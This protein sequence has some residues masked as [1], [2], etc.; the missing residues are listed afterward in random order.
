M[1]YMK[2]L[3]MFMPVMLAACS[4][5][6]W[7]ALADV[8]VPKKV[9]SGEFVRFVEDTSGAR[10]QTS[11]TAYRNADGV[12]VTLIGA[13]H[14]ADS[15]YYD[16]LND[17]FKS[18]DAVLYE[19][20]GGPIEKREE[21]MKA[22]EESHVSPQ[23]DKKNGADQATEPPIIQNA[24]ASPNP[25][26]Q[27]SSHGGTPAAGGDALSWL[28]ML[29][30]MLQN[31]LALE[32]QLDGIDYHQ[33]NFV[34][35]DMSLEEFSSMQQE[36]QEGFLALW[37]KAVQVQI[38][39]PQVTA[40]QPGLLQIL[41]IL[42]RQDSATE[43]KRLIGRTFD[44]VEGLMAGMEAGDGTVIITE[45]NKV[46]LKVMDEQIKAGKRNLAIFYGSAHLPDMEKRLQDM[47]FKKQQTTWMTAW[48]LPPPA[49]SVGKGMGK[50]ENQ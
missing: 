27:A 1:E 15:A 36:R 43:L 21:R 40:N 13:V 32:G 16:E 42:T 24:P 8:T 7:P 48:D 18:F 10:L 31:T 47:G 3:R 50:T 12:T 49:S 25:D 37:L 41:E 34:H 46:A 6:A 33:P 2:A 38:D 19:M 20:V 28:P 35:A 9:N 11:N 22:A 23:N 39:N 4:M 5:V 17:L 14:V 29:H 44:S 30:G 45:R 26:E